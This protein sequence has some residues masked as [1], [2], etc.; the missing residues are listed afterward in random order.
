MMACVS[1][2]ATVRSTPRRMGLG[3]SF[4]STLTCRSRISKVDMRCSFRGS[5]EGGVDV[6]QHALA[7]DG[8]GIDRDGAHGGGAG[9]LAGAQVE[10]RTVEPALDRAALDLAVGQRDRAVRADV[11]DGVQLAGVVTHDG[12]LDGTVLAFELDAER[13]LHGHVLV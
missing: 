11:A 6:D 2:L 10:A 4:V 3:P 9:G 5:S 1:P 13:A 7:V 12:D 8:H